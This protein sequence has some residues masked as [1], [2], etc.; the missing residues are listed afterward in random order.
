MDSYAK[1]I[2]NSLHNY[3]SFQGTVSLVYNVRK[4]DPIR[5]RELNAV[6]YGTTEALIQIAPEDSISTQMALNSPGDIVFYILS[7]FR[8]N[9]TVLFGLLIC[10]G[11]G[12]VLTFKVPGAIDI[13]KSILNAPAE[14]KLKKA[15]ADQK[16]LEIVEKKIEIYEKIKASG[17]N[18]GTL[19]QPINSIISGCSSLRVEPITLSDE[20]AANLPEEAVIPESHDAEEE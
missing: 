14:Y 10:L 3:Y 9:W 13:L 15:E 19:S 18:P 4:S 12:S 1:Y 2:L 17:I 16:E 5:P 11:G 6:L 20:T 8:D 7:F